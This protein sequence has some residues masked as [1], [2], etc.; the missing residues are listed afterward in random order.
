MP[1]TPVHLGPGMAIKAAAG[2]HFSIVVFGLTQVAIDI[3]VVW[4]YFQSGSPLHQFWHTTLGATVV[5]AVFAVAGKPASQAIKSAWNRLARRWSVPGL[6]VRV[7]TSWLAALTGAVIGAYSH[8]LFDSI[9]HRSMQPLWPWTTANPFFGLVK[10]T[11]F[12]VLCAIVG[13]LALAWYA[14]RQRQTQDGTCRQTGM[15]APPGQ[16]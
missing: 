7:H 9:F 10:R 1:Y 3:E 13:L 8:L 11:R 16:R 2:R 4:H 6:A 15:S 12:M 14:F 5:A